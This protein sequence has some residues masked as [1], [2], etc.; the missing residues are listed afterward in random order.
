MTKKKSA[1][2]AVETTKE[3]PKQYVVLTRI[4]YKA[5]IPGETEL[6]EAA[7]DPYAPDAPRVTLEHLGPV[8]V[9]RLLMRRIVAEDKPQAQKE[10]TG[11]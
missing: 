8:D 7:P 2:P 1:G 6:I 5:M 10:E 3:P 4:L 9:N 11:D